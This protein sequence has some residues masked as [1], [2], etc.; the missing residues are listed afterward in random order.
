MVY[1][2]QEA[3]ATSMRLFQHGTY[4]FI[5]ITTYQT[6]HLLQSAVKDTYSQEAIQTYYSSALF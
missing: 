5:V 2:R 6:K 3:A 1:D 4:S